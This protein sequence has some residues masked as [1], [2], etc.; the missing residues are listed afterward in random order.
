MLFVI[1]GVA[2]I[3]VGG[4]FLFRDTMNRIQYIER[5]RIYWITRDN[6]TDDTPFITRAF[7]RHTSP[8]YWRGKGVQFAVGKHT[9]QVGI[10]TGKAKA[11]VMSLQEWLEDEDEVTMGVV[12]QL[13]AHPLDD[14]VDQIRGD[15]QE[16]DRS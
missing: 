9:F 10:L 15:Y 2:L 3:I 13:D 12:V 7:M 5:L 4:Y 16:P 6:A 1:A 11:K 14:S 8:P